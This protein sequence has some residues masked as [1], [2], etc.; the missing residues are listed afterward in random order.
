AQRREQKLQK[1]LA[2]FQL[3][4]QHQ[5]SD[6]EVAMKELQE[7]LEITNTELQHKGQLAREDE[8]KIADLKTLVEAIQVANAN[9]SAKNAELS[10]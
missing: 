7:R 4:E 6:N 5:S 2:K 9:L 1:D 10:T 8:Q 3:E